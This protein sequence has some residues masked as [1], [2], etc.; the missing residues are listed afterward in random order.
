[1]S[2]RTYPAMNKKIANL[3]R[4]SGDPMHLY[5]AARIDELEEGNEILH[6]AILDL[7]TKIGKLEVALDKACVAW[8]D[9]DCPRASGRVYWPECRKCDYERIEPHDLQRDLACWK[10]YFLDGEEADGEK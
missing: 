7:Q 8:G 5:A 4:G 6:D 9:W 1:M 10:K 2:L 3:L